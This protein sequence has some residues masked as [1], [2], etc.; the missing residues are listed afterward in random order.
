MEHFVVSARKY[1]PQTFDSVVG[2]GSITTTLQNAIDQ[3]QL[4]QA[5]LFCG[6]RGVGKT[7]CARIFAKEINRDENLP[8]GEEQDLSFNIFE[9]DAASNNSV[10]DIRSLTDQVRIPPQVGTYRVF[11]IDEVHMLSQAAFNAFLKTLE[12]PPP[13]AIFILA[14][15]EK[16]KIIPTILSRCQIFDFNRIRIPDMVDHLVK[17]AGSEEIETERDGLHIIAQKADGALRDALSIFDQIVAFA[18]KNITYQSVIENLNIL[19]YGYYFKVTDHLVKGE[20]PPVLLLFNE[21]LNHGFDGHNFINGV[22]EHF[23]NLLVC[24]DESTVSLLEVGDSI[25]KRYLEQAKSSPQDFLL[26]GL[27]IVSRADVQYKSSKNQRLLIE[28]ALMQLCSLSEPVTDEKKKSRRL[29]VPTRI[30]PSEKERTRALSQ[31]KS[32]PEKGSSGKSAPSGNAAQSPPPPPPPPSRE[33]ESLTAVRNKM[34]LN[35]V[36]IQA[37]RNPQIDED[38][39]STPVQEESTAGKPTE[40]FSQE[41]LTSAWK[42]FAQLVKK[43]EKHNFYSTMLSRDPIKEDSVVRFLVDHEVQIEYFEKERGE[44]MGFLRRRLNNWGISL[45][46]EQSESEDEQSKYLTSVDKFKLMAEKN[47]LLKTL[48]QKMNLDIEH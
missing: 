24:K 8:E 25:K 21:I 16:H 13:H 18:G 26:D 12:E 14:T 15:T 34:R 37:I 9:L 40:P 19:D 39:G 22:G 11:I 46:I 7:T 35:T 45:Q 47:P 4:A 3:E 2:Q 28:L 17:I 20:I 38:D 27:G 29:S 30:K 1:R 5:Y 48:Q 36:S 33:I 10:E 42:N 41:A 44:L 6:P 23:R 31:R 32:A 43:E